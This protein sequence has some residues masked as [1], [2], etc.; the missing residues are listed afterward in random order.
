[1]TPSQFKAKA[2]EMFGIKKPE[3]IDTDPVSFLYSLEW[4]IPNGAAFPEEVMAQM[5]VDFDERGC[6]GRALKAAVLCE[7]LFPLYTLYAGEVCEDLLRKI[8]LEEASEEKW[9][10]DS[11]ISEIL[12]YE[13]PHIVIVDDEE[14]QFDP[15]F[16]LLSN[17]PKKLK[18]P[19]VLK[20]A[21]WEGLYCAYLVSWAML[22]RNSHVEVYFQTLQKAETLFP[23][24]ILI[25]ENLASACCLMGQYSESIDFAKEVSIKRKD[26]KTLFFLW[27]L[28]NEDIYKRALIEQ[29]D[30]RMFCFLTKNLQS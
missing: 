21:I 10:D 1:M 13:N 16:S 15:I 2:M 28:T 9:N 20:H 27:M 11:F 5:N 19:N 8:I 23:E 4:D 25:K 30:I 17:S 29:Y 26:A 12:Q 3:T 14:N 6:F 22:K 24:V 18:H 7:Q